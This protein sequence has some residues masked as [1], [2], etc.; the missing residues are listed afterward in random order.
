MPSATRPN[1]GSG[2]GLLVCQLNNDTLAPIAEVR[3]SEAAGVN[4]ARGSF[5]LAF[6]GAILLATLSVAFTKMADAS[7]VL[8]PAE[9]QQI[10]KT[11]EHD[12]EIISNSALE[13]QL[14]G[15]P[16]TTRDEVTR[17]NTDAR[18]LALQVALLIALAASLL[19]VFNSFRIRPRRASLRR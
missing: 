18:H 17:I 4:S 12:A 8:S 2:L 9:Q 13:K 19:G 7:A 3:A 11:L 15:Q 1:P 14:K 5:G 10:S 16:P 6:A